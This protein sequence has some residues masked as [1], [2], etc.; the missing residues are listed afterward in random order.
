MTLSKIE[1]VSCKDQPVVSVRLRT[2]WPS[3]H[4]A[5]VLGEGQDQAF[6]I[7]GLEAFDVPTCGPKLAV[8]TNA[9]EH[10]NVKCESWRDKFGVIH[11]CL[12]RC[13]VISDREHKRDGSMAN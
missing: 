5:F 4:M 9:H 12:Q 2:T 13:S 1:C 3:Y 6:L 11:P 10:L 7:S 8:F